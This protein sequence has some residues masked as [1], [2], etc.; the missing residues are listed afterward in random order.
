M[1]NQMKNQMNNQILIFMMK[2]RNFFIQNFMVNIICSVK[3]ERNWYINRIIT[4][5]YIFYSRII[6][7]LLR[8]IPFFIIKHIFAYLNKKIIYQIDD[9]YYIEPCEQNHILPIIMNLEFVNN[10]L[11]ICNLTNKIKFYNSSIP[12]NFF[13]KQHNLESYN[14]IKLK[15]L[16]KGTI[17]EKIVKIN[18]KNCLIYNLFDD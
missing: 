8:F 9:I 13:I 2:C 6:R 18:N 17:I 12:I 7:V 1:K 5:R 14:T 4:H 11:D 10:N 3:S 15:Y 16:K